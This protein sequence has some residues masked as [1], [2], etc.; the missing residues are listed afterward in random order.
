M[1]DIDFKARPKAEGV[2]YPNS[3][4]DNPKKPDFTGTVKFDVR[5]VR[6]MVEYIREYKE[7]TGNEPE[8]GVEM[9]VAQWSRISKE[10]QTPYTYTTIESPIKRNVA[11]AP[12]P[13]PEPASKPVKK[14]EETTLTEDEIPF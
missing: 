8:E 7:R 13:A 12:E 14:A 1:S 3:Y 5:L 11:P 10:K 4:K 2:V 6:E 9:R